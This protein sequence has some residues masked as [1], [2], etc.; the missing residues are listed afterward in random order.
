MT[1]SNLG[2]I[3]GPTL[4]RSQEE[5][6]AAMMNIKF[7]NIVVEIII[8]NH[9]KVLL[10]ISKYV[11][12]N[13]H[14]RVAHTLAGHVSCTL[15]QIFGEA[16]DL[17]LP[18]PQAPSSR[19]TPRRN[20]AIC[21]SSGKRRARLYPPALCLANDSK[22]TLKLFRIIIICVFHQVLFGAGWTGYPALLICAIFSDFDIRGTRWLRKSLS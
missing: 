18:L 7:Q 11:K 2:M 17:S 16:P 20:K 4:M 19:S 8:E 15:G 6:V 10:P 21:L 1:V 12:K 5:T 22:I 9:H 13:I 14:K 3:F